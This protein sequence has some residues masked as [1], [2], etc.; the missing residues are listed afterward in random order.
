MLLQKF[1]R[2]GPIIALGFILLMFLT[3]EAGEINRHLA[4]L[5][6]VFAAGYIIGLIIFWYLLRRGNR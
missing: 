3:R 1:I 5:F 6:M 2:F 4:Y